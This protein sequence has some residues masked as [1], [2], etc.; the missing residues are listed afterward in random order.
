MMPIFLLLTVLVV[1]AGSSPEAYR[2]TLVQHQVCRQH[3]QELLCSCQPGDNQTYLGLRIQG[4][5][6]QQNMRQVREPQRS[7]IYF[8]L[9]SLNYNLQTQLG[10]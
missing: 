9:S 2:V 7:E 5:L 3:Q 1:L 10:K 8:Q 4:F 6:R